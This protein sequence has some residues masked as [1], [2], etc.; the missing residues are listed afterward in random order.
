MR[1]A[2]RSLQRYPDLYARFMR[3]A[4]GIMR[5]RGQLSAA[6][7]Q[8]RML[9]RKFTIDR[10]DITI[11]QAAAMLNRTMA[12]DDPSTQ[13]RV[14]ESALRQFGISAGMGAFD[15]L[16]RPFFEHALREGRKEDAATILRLTF[17]LIPIEADTQ[18]A[19]EMETL[20]RRL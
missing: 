8:E 18:F 2:A 13:L 16:V 19:T 20:V 3:E 1:E 4:I 15:R 11:A 14:F 10:S 5:E 9:A 17:R 6:D 12:E 7:H